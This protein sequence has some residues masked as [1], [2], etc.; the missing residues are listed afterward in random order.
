MRGEGRGA[1]EPDRHHLGC[2]FFPYKPRLLCPWLGPDT[3]MSSSLCLF[4]QLPDGGQGNKWREQDGGP[5]QP[6]H[7]RVLPDT[8]TLAGVWK[9]EFFLYWQ[10][11]NL[12][13]AFPVP[14]TPFLYA[15]CVRMCVFTLGLNP[16]CG[17]RLAYSS[18]HNYKGESW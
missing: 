5:R 15:A 8:Q 17:G 13:M 11:V 10:L 4:L 6:S 12:S 14:P 7:W 9:R 1:R 2:L 3:M 16:S 18:S